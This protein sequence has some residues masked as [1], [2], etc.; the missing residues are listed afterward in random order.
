MLEVQP[1]ANCV[2]LLAV[3]DVSFFNPPPVCE[4]LLSVCLFSFFPLS[5]SLSVLVMFIARI[6]TLFVASNESN[7][8]KHTAFILYASQFIIPVHNRC[9]S[10]SSNNTW[11]QQSCLVTHSS[12]I[13]NQLLHHYHHCSQKLYAIACSTPDIGCANNAISVRRRGLLRGALSPRG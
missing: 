4:R 5:L 8:S 6:F 7:Q 11:Q 12:T 13:N 3:A 10:G 1:A 2:E 9:E